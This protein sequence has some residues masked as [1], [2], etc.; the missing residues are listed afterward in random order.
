[1]QAINRTRNTIL[2]SQGS[3]ADNPLTRLK[4][5]LGHAPLQAGEGL[6][7]RGEKSIHSIG[8]GFDIDAL[9]LDAAGKVVYLM[10]VMVPLRFSPF[11]WQSADVLEVPAGTI[12]R[13]G[14][15]LGDQI[16]ITL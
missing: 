9:F 5:L 14:T 6:L 1:V 7:L 3:I 16:E 8:M 11:V 10:P 2:V 12:A 15:V 13:T 4:G